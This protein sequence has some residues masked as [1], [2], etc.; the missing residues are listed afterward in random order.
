MNNQYGNVVLITGASSGIGQCTAL[1]L[2]SL[3]FRV[4]GGSR[5]GGEDAE[6]DNGFVKMLKLDVCDEASVTAAVSAVMA[7]EGRID[8]LVNAAGIGICGSVEEVSAEEAHMQMDTNYLGVVRMLNVVLPHMRKARNGLVV[9]IG[10]V[11]GIFS[12]PFQTHYSSSKYA[13]ESLTEGL[14]IEMRPFNVRAAL[15]EPGDTKTAFTS[16]RIY[17]E[18][19]RNSAYGREFRASVAQMEH[20]EQ[21]GK[22]PDTVTDVILQV[23]KAKNPPVRKVV[24]ASYKVLVFLKRLL[25]ARALESLLTMM[26]PKSKLGDK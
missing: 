7:A 8:I 5:R 14:R 9:N 4:Y 25:P 20:D 21:A 15:V 6:F 26:Y 16:S 19:A 12:I 23:I 1:R 10:S 24:G 2:A 13:L 17:A 18:K 11:G 22:A 3:G